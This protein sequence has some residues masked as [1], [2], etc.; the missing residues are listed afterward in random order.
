VGILISLF[1]CVLLISLF[2]CVL[3]ISLFL[4]GSLTQ[5]C[6]PINHTV[7]LEKEGCP[8]VPSHSNPYLRFSTVYLHVCTY[9]DVPYETIRLPDC[10]PWV[11]PC[12]TYPVA[13]SCDCTCSQ[14][15]DC[16]IESLQPDF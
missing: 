15:S 6:Q 12:V 4:C 2:L 13:L 8:N 1:L 10:P 16:T 7:S 5:P 3:L 11:D 9:R 14:T